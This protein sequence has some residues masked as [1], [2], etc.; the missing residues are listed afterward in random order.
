MWLPISLLKC[1]EDQES[2]SAIGMQM[3]CVFLLFI[4]LFVTSCSSV[5]LDS[6][7]VVDFRDSSAIKS[8]LMKQYDE[9]RTT[10]YK[11]GGLSKRGIDCSGFTYLTFRSKLGCNLP[12]T[13]KL[14][15]KTGVKVS[16]NNLHTGDLVF[17]KTGFFIKH[18]G[19]YLD[20]SQF[21]HTS[22]SHG[23]MISSLKEK[24]WEKHY[25]TA[26]RICN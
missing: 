3:N 26:R 6:S 10:P 9:W 24:Y 11:M 16:R 13:T 22:T 12:R 21:L 7:S 23:V 5:R 19:I 14:Q 15:V 8:I 2:S 20:E 18:V 25:W 17:F 4:C 1:T